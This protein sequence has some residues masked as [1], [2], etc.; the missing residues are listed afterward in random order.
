MQTSRARNSAVERAAAAQVVASAPF[1][2]VPQIPEQCSR[3]LRWVEKTRLAIMPP[4][5]SSWCGLCCAVD[6]IQGA[7]KESRLNVAMEE[8]AMEILCRVHHVL[9]GSSAGGQ[10][11]VLDATAAQRGN[12]AVADDVPAPGTTGQARQVGALER[13]DV[14]AET[15]RAEVCPPD[16]KVASPRHG[17][18]EKRID[19]SRESVDLLGD[20][21]K[22]GSAGPSSG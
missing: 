11:T 3:C 4:G 14:S 13:S 22:R 5:S 6:A 19:G 9:R 16:R 20:G 18:G 1:F 2:G 15:R 12:S 21:T 7:I 8:E 10:P 17:A